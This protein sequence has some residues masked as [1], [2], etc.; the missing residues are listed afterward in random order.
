[1]DVDQESNIDESLTNSMVVFSELHSEDQIQEPIGTQAIIRASAI[2][3]N[4]AEQVQIKAKTR[5][6]FANPKNLKRKYKLNDLDNSFDYAGSSQ[7]NNNNLKKIQRIRRD[8]KMS[9]FSNF[10]EDMCDQDFDEGTRR[11]INKTGGIAKIPNC[12]DGI[13]KTTSFNGN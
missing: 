9:N 11:I 10:S 12:S 5:S 3:K 7:D 6:K 4:R 13:R 1:M 2:Q 8:D